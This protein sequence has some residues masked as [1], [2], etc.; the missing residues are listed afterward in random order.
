MFKVV[1]VDVVAVVAVTVVADV[2]VVVVTHGVCPSGQS[3]VA[4]TNCAQIGTPLSGLHGP[5]WKAHTASPQL[6]S[7]LATVPT[8]PLKKSRI[9]TARAI[10]CS[11]VPQR[12][13]DKQEQDSVETRE[14]SSG[15][16]V[17]S[18]EQHVLRYP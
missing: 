11:A 10:V 3:W 1:V 2:V 15:C 7:W 16:G 6:N 9:W 4:V 12:N 18:C 8:R 14:L 13:L 17:L 5:S